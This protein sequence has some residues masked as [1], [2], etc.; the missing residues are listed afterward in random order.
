MSLTDSYNYQDKNTYTSFWQKNNTLSYNPN[1]NKLLSTMPLNDSLYEIDSNYFPFPEIESSSVPETNIDNVLQEV[2]GEDGF[3]HYI[4]N[5]EQQQK[6]NA[7]VEENALA[8]YDF[9][10]ESSV[11]DISSYEIEYVLR[12]VLTDEMPENDL[13]D[14]I[15]QLSKDNLNANS[16]DAKE[17]NPEY[18]EL[19]A[20]K[21]ARAL[22]INPDEID[23][24]KNIQGFEHLSLAQIAS[25]LSI[26]NKDINYE[27]KT[28]LNIPISE[29]QAHDVKEIKAQIHNM[30][31]LN[32]RIL[33]RYDNILDFLQAALPKGDLLNTI[34]KMAGFKTDIKQLKKSSKNIKD[35]ITQ[36]KEKPETKNDNIL[37]IINESFNIIGTLALSA[38]RN[39]SDDNK[40]ALNIENSLIV[41]KN[42]MQALITNGLSSDKANN[43]KIIMKTITNILAPFNN[44]QNNTVLSQITELSKEITNKDIHSD[45]KDE[46]NN[47]GGFIGR[48]I[49]DSQDKDL[50]I[51]DLVQSIPAMIQSL[52]KIMKITIPN[53]VFDITKEIFTE[54]SNNVRIKERNKYKPK[55]T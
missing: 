43:I 48:I 13:D 18:K 6:F 40:T 49:A 15:I 53:I 41:A 2:L 3:N 34:N 45:E 33:T 1:Q 11:E 50:D 23:K 7:W 35:L 29:L 42:A 12:N 20:L 47:L 9:Q 28:E 55:T 26:E 17:L 27:F 19:L 22:N 24:I 46:I 32:T 25:R 39:T 51:Q 52:L 54:I 14:L 4:E 38:K 16:T 37:K 21:V 8:N 30:K 36:S 44:T 10:S 5:T 31:R